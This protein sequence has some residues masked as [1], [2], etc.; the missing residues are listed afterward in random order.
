MGTLIKF[1]LRKILGNKAGMVACVLAFVLLAVM[2]A[3]NLSTAVVRDFNTGEVARGFEAQQVLKQ[4]TLS[5]AGVLDD[6]HVA[7][8]AQTLDLANELAAQ[9]PNFDDM[10]TQQ[11]ID[12]YGLEFARQSKGVR[13]DRYYYEVVGTLDCTEPRAT[14]LQA[15]AEARLANA[16]AN[17]EAGYSEA[18]KA[19]WTDKASGIAWPL[20]YGYAEGWGNYLDY[21]SFAAL[22][23]VALCIALSGVFAG[24]YQSGAAAIALPTRRG[25]R[26]LP[27]AKVVAALLFAT[28]YW[29]LCMFVPLGIN[30]AVCGAEGWDLP[31]QIID[32]FDNPYPFTVGQTVLLTIGLSLLVTLGMAALTLALSAKLRSTMPVAVIPMAITFLGL[33]GLF[34]GWQPLTKLALLT[35]LAGLNYAFIRMVSYAAG[36]FVADLPTVL[37]VLYAATL[38]V[39][40]P[41]AMRTFKRHQVA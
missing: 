24:E 11:I 28:A 5:H 13:N 8:D 1:E 37:A 34:V 38:V 21:L 39:L 30:I 31:L 41:L 35:P 19:Y 26:A 23:I 3:M 9:V 7:A 14:S 4:R 22:A 16:L 6:A 29:C 18:E 36:S 25:K 15:G 20:E 27:A 17:D 33:M 2:A 40:V 10:D 12:E 32:G